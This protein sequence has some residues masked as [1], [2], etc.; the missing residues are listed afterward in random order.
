[1][2]HFVD[3]LNDDR[4]AGIRLNSAM[5]S[6]VELDKELEII[7]DEVEP[8]TVPLYYDI[9]GRQLRV[10]EIIPL[11]THLELIL[12][13]P[14]TVQTPTPVLFKA[15]ADHA[16][17]ESVEDDGRRLVFRGGP[18]YSV[19]AGES[20]HI[21]H[22]S[23]EIYGPLFTSLEKEKISKVRAAGLDKWFLSYVEK[24]S[25][26]DEFRELVGRDAELMLKIESK[27][28]MKFVAQEFRKKDNVSLIA[29][30]GDLYVELD[31]P[32]E[33]LAATK[34]I[35]AKDPGACVASRLML[36]TVRSPIPSCSDFSEL[37]WLYDIGYRK[38]MLCDELCLKQEFL[39]PA[40]SAFDAFRGSY[41]EARLREAA[42]RA[43]NASSEDLGKAAVWDAYKKSQ[44]LVEQFP[45]RRGKEK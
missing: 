3:F 40:V 29:A 32:H 43:F 27:K 35:L 33:I 44:G 25:D 45:T 6:L 20:L 23:L 2:P 41:V 21:R 39:G 24:Q 31:H 7:E 14:I 5:M 12:N 19:R 11:K 30:R 18:R 34:L 15:G 1:M 17:L 28:G 4:L 9:K 37:A 42:D 38:V 10:E 26:V 13:H 16:L 8:G 36:S 22:P